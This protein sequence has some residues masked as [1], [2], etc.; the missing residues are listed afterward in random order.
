M[1]EK[2]TLN[3]SFKPPPPS[4]TPVQELR[5]RHTAP[6]LRDI[7]S[8]K[9]LSTKGSKDDLVLRLAK[10]ESLIDIEDVKNTFTLKQLSTRVLCNSK[11]KE[12]MC[13]NYLQKL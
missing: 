13:R 5:R 4:E 12:E 11:S 6:E 9:D 1:D 10:S 8:Q 2:L 3:V 7:L